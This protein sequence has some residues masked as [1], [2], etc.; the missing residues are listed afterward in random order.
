MTAGAYLAYAAKRANQ[1][2]VEAAQAVRLGRPDIA[3]MLRQSARVY[4]D[5]ARFASMKVAA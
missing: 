5:N 3:A 4:L 1:L 2:R